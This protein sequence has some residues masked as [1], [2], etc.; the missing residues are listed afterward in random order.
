MRNSPYKLILTQQNNLIVTYIQNIHYV[1]DD[2]ANRA[3]GQVVTGGQ[4]CCV[5]QQSALQ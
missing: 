4:V 3:D 5:T 1:R 2:A